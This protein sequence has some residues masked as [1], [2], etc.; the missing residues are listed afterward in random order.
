MTDPH[1]SALSASVSRHP[2][3][4]PAG[5]RY[6]TQPHQES[7]LRLVEDVA[8]DKSDG[9]TTPEEKRDELVD[10]LERCA[11]NM[12]ELKERQRYSDHGAFAQD[13][14][15]IKKAQGRLRLAELDLQDFDDPIPDD[16]SPVN[17]AEV[18]P[19]DTVWK[20]EGKWPE[21][22]VDDP[23]FDDQGRILAICH[24]ERTDRGRVKGQTQ[25]W[26]AADTVYATREDAELHRR[27]AS[28]VGDRVRAEY[29]AGLR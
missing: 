15:G 24:W 4:T 26:P 27:V 2:A 13:A 3:G 22:V 28:R 29:D 11:A 9:P 5:G 14:E 1:N 8:T 7:N 12:V 18:K 23:P 10:Q 16:P 20:S 25:V 21:I 19:G 6:A 17:V